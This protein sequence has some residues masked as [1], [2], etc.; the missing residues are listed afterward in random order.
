V[1][2]DNL[3]KGAGAL[4]AKGAI[5]LGKAVDTSRPVGG[6]WLTSSP[7]PRTTIDGVSMTWS[8]QI[9]WG[10]QLIWGTGDVTGENVVWNDPQSW[11]DSIV[12]GDSAIGY[13]QGQQII[14]GTTVGL[15]PST[16]AWKYIGGT[17]TSSGSSKVQ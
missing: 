6:A 9:I 17:A 16:T 1:E 2:Y 11:A 5:D 7:V 12:W 10:T 4:N 13:D 14:W 3:R 15:T 8:Q